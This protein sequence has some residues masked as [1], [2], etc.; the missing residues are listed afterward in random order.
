MQVL[1]GA[2]EQPEGERRGE[3]TEREGPGDQPRPGEPRSR[4][5]TSHLPCSRSHWT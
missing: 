1:P 2:P 5:E 4:D 3:G